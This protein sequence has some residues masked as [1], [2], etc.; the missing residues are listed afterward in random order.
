MTFLVHLFLA[1]AM[2]LLL[3]VVFAAGFGRRGPWG[4]TWAFLLVVFLTAWALGVWLTPLG[5]VEVAVAWLP[6]V[7]GGVIAAA[8]LT[9]AGGRQPRGAAGGRGPGAA[10]AAVGAFFWG[11]LAVLAMTVILGYAVRG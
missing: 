10:R 7:L 2:A 8:A 3:T 9:A 5:P 1:L 6:F 4:T 11:L